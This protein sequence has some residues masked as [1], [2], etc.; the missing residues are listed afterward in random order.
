[1]A[2]TTEPVSLLT[3]AGLEVAI[4][5]ATPEAI[6]QRDALLVLARK[7]KI[8]NSPESAQ[9]AGLVL[10]DLKAFTRLIEE[11]RKAVKA[12]VLK[13]EDDIDALAKTLTTQIKAEETRIGGLIATYQEEQRR[14]EQAE[15]EAAFKE[16]QRLAAEHAEKERKAREAQEA[17]ARRVREEQER[18]AREAAELEAKA[19]RARSAER[20]A[21]LQKEADERRA[22]AEKEAA[23][24]EEARKA[25][26]AKA[27]QER[28]EAAK[29]MAA[30][31]TRV[32]MSVAPKLEGLSLRSETKFE[33][34]DIHALHAHI[35]ALV[36]LTPNNA[37]IKAQLKTLPEGQSL[38]GV[39]HWKEAKTSVR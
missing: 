17:E 25:A 21:Q 16:Q 1:M 15:R 12:P 36:I 8:V 33:V 19:N 5:S 9:R 39:R 4:P 29:A 30:Q 38:P 26:E 7:G 31:N 24:A 11:T 6:A 14:R 34:T 13:L 23:A 2:T 35:P 18:A 10:K 27:E 28:N 20:Q 22:Q 37:A 32:S 3:I